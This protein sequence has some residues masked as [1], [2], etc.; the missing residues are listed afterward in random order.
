[1]LI[2]PMHNF[3]S[4]QFHLVPK[5]SAIYVCMYVCMY[6]LCMYVCMFVFI[7][8]DT[9]MMQDVHVKLNPGL[10]WQKQHSTKR[11]LFLPAK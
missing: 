5:L 11:R 8:K 7:Y 3:I 9:Y 2:I 6:V 4:L 10:P 1:M